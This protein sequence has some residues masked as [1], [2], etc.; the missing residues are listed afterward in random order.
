MKDD[1]LRKLSGKLFQFLIAPYF[2]FYLSYWL[3]LLLIVCADVE[4]NPGP[5]SDKGVRVP[6]PIFVVFMTI[7]RVGCDWIG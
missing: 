4:S 2:F 5:G 7:E 6:F 1:E 3:L